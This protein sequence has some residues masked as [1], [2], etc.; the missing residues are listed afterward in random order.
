MR[1]DSMHTSLKLAASAVLAA[2]LC[3]GTATAAESTASP[4]A[5]HVKIYDP[6]DLAPDRYQVVKR[7]WVESW[8]SAFRV[9]AHADTGAA[10]AELQAEAARV[11]ANALL[12]LVCIP[13]SGWQLRKQPSVFCYALA[14]RLR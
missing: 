12:N 14:I 6:A 10:V 1:E 13:D 5:E 9:P 11:G 8:R 4:G 2:M 7:L 3:A